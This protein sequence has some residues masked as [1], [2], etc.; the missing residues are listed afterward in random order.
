MVGHF[1]FIVYILINKMLDLKC[2]N[3]VTETKIPIQ[4]FAVWWCSPSFPYTD[5]HA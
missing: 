4:M 2:N 1:F 5:T 3:S